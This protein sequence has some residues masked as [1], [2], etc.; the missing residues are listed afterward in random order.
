[1]GI[2]LKK[3]SSSWTYVS[4]LLWELDQVGCFCLWQGGGLKNGMAFY[5]LE[6]GHWA[7]S[8]AQAGCF[9]SIPSDGEL[10][11]LRCHVYVHVAVL[12]R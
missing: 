4:D 7:T 10:Y 12:W 6:L 3:L 2:L 11:D 5:M 8:L 9:L 1:M